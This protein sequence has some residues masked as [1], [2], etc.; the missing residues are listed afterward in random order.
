MGLVWFVVSLL[1]QQ[2]IINIACKFV[3]VRVHNTI[4]GACILMTTISFCVL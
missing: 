3:C 1:N 2:Y 4:I